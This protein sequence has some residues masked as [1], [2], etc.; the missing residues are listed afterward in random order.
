MTL[1]AYLFGF[2][3]STLMGSSFHL[4]KGGGLG[5]L[6]L[7]LALSWLGFILGHVI[8]HQFGWAII[9]VGPLHLGLAIIGSIAFLVVGHWLSQIQVEKHA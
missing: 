8:A 1:P 5:R 2:C 3:V 9:D 6:I 7:D 4:L